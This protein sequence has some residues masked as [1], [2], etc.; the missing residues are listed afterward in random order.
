[1]NPA[2]QRITEIQ[3]LLTDID[4]DPTHPANDARHP[5]H[6]ICLIGV[7]TLQFEL[8]GLHTE[9]TVNRLLNSPQ[10]QL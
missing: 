8:T 2:K 1:M 6:T 7:S 9:A 3:N 5:K 10:V 4:G